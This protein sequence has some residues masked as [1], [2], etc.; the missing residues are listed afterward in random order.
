ML[1]YDEWIGKI[2]RLDIFKNLKKDLDN[3]SDQCYTLNE[4]LGKIEYE[5]DAKKMDF[6]KLRKSV[7]ICKECGQEIKL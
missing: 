1:N 4:K 5:L 3:C 7:K 2:E 6:E